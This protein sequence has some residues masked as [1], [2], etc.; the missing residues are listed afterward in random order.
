MSIKNY[1][2]QK[3]AIFYDW[4]NQW[5][6]AERVLLDILKIYPHADLFTLVHDPSKSTWLP[7]NIKI[8]TSFINHLP[9]SK[10]NPIFYTP[11][12]DIALE[13]FD[14]S[15]YDIVIS[16]T[17]VLGHCLLT[18]PHTLFLT[19]FHNINRHLYSY[20]ILRP[21]QKIDQLYGHRPD[22]ILC[23]SQTVKARLKNAYHRTPTVINPGIDTNFF[24]PTKHPQN[25][26]FL[27]VGRQ[28]AHKKTDL[29]VNAF[30]SLPYQLIIA[31]DGR[32]H[33]YLV[34][35][36]SE[37]NNIKLLG[38]VSESKLLS[39]YQHCQALICPQLE[40]FGLAAIEAQS[41]GKPVIAYNRGGNTETII[42]GKTGILFDEQNI[43]SLKASIDTFTKA[44]FDSSSIRQHAL[45]FSHSSFMLNFKQSVD[46][47]WQQ[48]LT[49]MS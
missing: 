12:Y 31:G 11:F 45:K 40:D 23:N 47:L 32:Q 41:C 27:V 8:T 48:H 7:K 34:N 29:V 1:S 3:I 28:V 15:N 24:K 20:P 16:T 6:G 4:L 9:F 17:S 14:F 21:Y 42:N 18:P 44:K 43:E 49:T 5:G 22:A 39:L 38:Q 10:N 25:N 30:K 2:K 26:Y 37:S 36:A 13:Q 33:D 35:L 19:Y 46:H